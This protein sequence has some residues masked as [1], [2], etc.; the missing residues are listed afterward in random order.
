MTQLNSSDEC[1][2]YN[3]FFKGVF[4]ILLVL[5]SF[6]FSGAEVQGKVEWR[7]WF[8]QA[9]GFFGTGIKLLS[10]C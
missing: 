9:G 7:R 10:V 3:F 2:L 8:H 5:L 4:F 6:L 1:D